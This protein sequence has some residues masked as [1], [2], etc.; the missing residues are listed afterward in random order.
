MLA[1]LVASPGC[2]E[3]GAS[4]TSAA[5]P[6]IGGDPAFQ[7]MAVVALLDGNARTYCTG[8]VI[9][10]RLVLTAAH[11]I[12]GQAGEPTAIFVGYQVPFDGRSAAVKSRIIHPDYEPETFTADLAL[13]ELWE[14]TAVTPVQV[15][16]VAMNEQWQ[17]YPIRLLG[18]GYTTFDDSAEVGV[19]NQITVSIEEVED[20]KFRYGEATCQ[21]DSGGPALVRF[22]GED[23]VIGVTSSGPPE[24]RFYG[25]SIRVDAYSDWISGEMRRLDPEWCEQSGKCP[26]EITAVEPDSCSN[27]GADCSAFGCSVA[28]GRSRSGSGAV[29]LMLLALALARAARSRRPLP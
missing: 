25:R 15:S 20:T 21:G 22:E 16:T 7:D 12:P 23:A 14:P 6:I 18:Y 1:A 13:V 5:A 17:G 24:C 28:A 26:P 11:C 4:F 9:S 19:K 27:G 29:I 10:P 2:I 3:E 8:T